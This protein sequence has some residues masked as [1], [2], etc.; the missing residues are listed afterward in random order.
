MDTIGH[1]C[2]PQ[3]YGPLGERKEMGSE[4]TSVDETEKELL[5]ILMDAGKSGLGIDCFS[6]KHVP[7]TVLRA[8][9][10]GPL[11]SVP[12]GSQLVQFNGE[13]TMD[14]TAEKLIWKLSQGLGAA[15]V[16][17]QLIFRSPPVMSDLAKQ[18]P[19]H[20]SDALL[21]SEDIIS[22]NVS[23]GELGAKFSEDAFFPI[24]ISNFQHTARST[25]TSPCTM[26][27][28]IA[29][30]TNS[31]QPP[32]QPNATSTT[33]T[34]ATPLSPLWTSPRRNASQVPSASGYEEEGVRVKH[35]S[36]TFPGLS[37]KTFRRRSHAR[38]TGAIVDAHDDFGY[39]ILKDKVP[40]WSELLQVNGEST[41]EWTMSDLEQFLQQST[42]N[43]D[44][45]IT[46]VFRVPLTVEVSRQGGGYPLRTAFYTDVVPP[47]IKRFDS[48]PSTRRFSPLEDSKVPRMSE[49]RLCNGV[50]T[51]AWTCE[52]LRET[53]Q[54]CQDRS[55]TL[56]FR[57]PREFTTDL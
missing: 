33:T 41:T 16:L 31:A 12:L 46:M 8:P 49:L 11:T 30:P 1:G 54:T 17:V 48:E 20:S 57:R 37:L 7:P 29:T 45:H 9:S 28:I 5:T 24:C 39:E 42:S 6:M 38:K 32:T 43:N 21:P 50:D 25:T 22:V 27:M 15:G 56:T 52:T 53:L 3:T 55:V 10:H 40:R 36:K 2:S 18:V 13:D 23:P 34:I 14:W 44:D 19:P 26:P 51:S 4:A 47:R 35:R